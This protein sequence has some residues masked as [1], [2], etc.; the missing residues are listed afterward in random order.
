MNIL[1]YFPEDK[2]YMTQWQRVH[3]FDEIGRYGYKIHVYNP[4]SYDS[5]DHANENLIKFIKNSR[6]KYELFMSCANSDQ[7]YIET[8]KNIKHLGLPTLLICFDNLHAPFLH[9]KI[10]SYFDLVWLTSFETEYIFKKWGCKTIILPYAANPYKFKPNYNKEIPAIG[11]IGTP[12]GIRLE[13]INI[14]IKNNLSCHLYSSRIENKCNKNQNQLTHYQLLKN[15]F[16]LSKFTIGR[17]I[18]SGAFLKKFAKKNASLEL[19]NKNLRI[20]PSVSFEEMNNLY[21]NLAISLGITELR[22]TYTLKK[23]VDKIH[24]RTFEV[25]MCGGIQLSSYSGELAGYF[26]NNKEIIL[27]QDNE[28]MISKANF[29]LKPENEKMR[30]NIKIAARK[31]A[32]NEH[33]WIHRFN[34]IFETINI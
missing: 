26:E 30:M 15:F 29:Y 13:K 9:K 27:Y 32:E 1:Y 22:N 7:I 6:I 19:D 14:L 24:L 10:A 21:S 20:L 4:L 31:R 11:F 18:I 28:E 16:N 2:S 34:K 8:I 3:I 5:L 17:K 23:P 12:Y 25:P 33:T